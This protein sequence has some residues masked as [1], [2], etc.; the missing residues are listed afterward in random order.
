M[1]LAISKIVISNEYSRTWAY[2]GHWEYLLKSLDHW[3]SRNSPS[4]KLIVP[5]ARDVR[6][7]SSD[8]LE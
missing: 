7:S 4:F 1:A 6:I 3:E 5:I 8:D 2:V